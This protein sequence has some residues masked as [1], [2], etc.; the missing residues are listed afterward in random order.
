MVVAAVVGGVVVVLSVDGVSGTV[1]VS[2]VGDV[3]ALGSAVVAVVFRLPPCVL[4]AP[5]VLD[6]LYTPTSVFGHLS[7][8]SSPDAVQNSNSLVSDRKSVV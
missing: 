8:A 2:V 1:V 6:F 7:V 4:H 3:V 5:G